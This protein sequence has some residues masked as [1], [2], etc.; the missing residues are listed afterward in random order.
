MVINSSAEY[1]SVKQLRHQCS[2]RYDR[3]NRWKTGM[4]SGQ[5]EPDLQGSS[6]A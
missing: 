4:S 5:E 6:L 2:V 1:K 3:R